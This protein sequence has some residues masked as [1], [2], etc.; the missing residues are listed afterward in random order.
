LWFDYDGDRDLDLVVANDQTDT[1]SFRL[2]RQMAEAV[3]TDVT[4]ESGPFVPYTPPD[5]QAALPTQ[6][7]GMCHFKELGI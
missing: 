4:V 3:F 5:G 1:T 7:G 6:R 2:F